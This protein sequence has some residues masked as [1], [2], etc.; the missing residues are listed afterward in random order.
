MMLA[1]KAAKGTVAN[2]YPIPFSNSSEIVIAS[3]AKQ[4]IVT[5]ENRKK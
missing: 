4:S 3:E 5:R 2:V 1:S